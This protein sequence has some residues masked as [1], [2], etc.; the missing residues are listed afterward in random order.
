VTIEA[1][2]KKVARLKKEILSMKVQRARTG[3]SRAAISQKIR[4]FHRVR[5]ELNEL[6]GIRPKTFT[7]VLASLP[8]TKS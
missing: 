1:L 3:G 4:D 5:R 8:E 6:Q 2:K 7:E